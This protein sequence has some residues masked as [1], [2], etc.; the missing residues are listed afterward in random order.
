M[1]RPSRIPFR[2]LPL[3]AQLYISAVSALGVSALSWR[4]VAF[5]LQLGTE[6]LLLF[7]LALL[8]GSH[9]VHLGTK[10]EMS[11]ALPF[12]FTALLSRGLAT[13]IDVSVLCMIATCVF[14]RNPFEPHRTLFNVSSLLLTTLAAG[15]VLGAMAGRARPPGLAELLLPL[16]ASVATYY[17]SNT[18]MVACAVGL[19]R[20]VSIA[21]LWQESFLW[22]VVSYFAGGSLAVGTS[23]MLS[24]LG[25]ASIA[26]ALPPV[27]LIQYS[28]KL[29]LSRMEERRAR[30]EAV[31]QLNA[32]LEA[33]VEQRTRELQELNARLQDSNTELQRANRLK[34]EFLAN[35]SHELRTPL[36]AIIGFSELLREGIHG[37]LNDEQRDFVGDIH[38]SGRH[39]LS[40]INGI[41]DLSKIEAGRMTLHREEFSF[42][43]LVRECVTVVRPLALKKHLVV[44]C[45]LGGAPQ[46]AWADAGMLRQILFNLLSNAVK[47]TPEGGRIEVRAWGEGRHLLVSVSDTGIGIANEDHERVFTEFYQVD[48]S[49]ARRYQGTGLGLALARRFV[50]LHGG[51]ISLDS[52]PGQGSTFTFRIPDGA[53]SFAEGAEAEPDAAGPATPGPADTATDATILVVED[54]PANMKLT[55]SLLQ[56]AGFQVLEADRA[57]RA[58]ELLGSA[59][60]DLI[61]MDIQLPGLDGLGLTRQLKADARTRAIPVVALTAHAMKGDEERALQAGC[62]GYIPKPIDPVRF[63]AQV[64]G[65]LPAVF[66]T[67]LQEASGR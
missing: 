33:K 27:L 51:T 5:P 20:R 9:T 39:L 29:Y 53:R 42:P 28:Y 62:S 6:D 48:G 25:L 52:E 22:T 37:S 54:N 23:W 56:H 43:P 15:Q 55:A 47:F 35:M 50:E 58:I 38:D 30:V 41:L 65:Y 57:E 18:A 34:S 4:L 16:T 10:V 36:N 45:R 11:A 67:T 8:L 61:L 1:S 21:K 2:N 44:D 46:T 49:Y 3:G 7:V 60:P 63:A 17:V 64:A 12:I 14:R 19:A 66:H 59:Q 31:E 13:A 24:T 32:E 40:L 26:L